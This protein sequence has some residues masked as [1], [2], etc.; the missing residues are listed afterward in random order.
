MK[1]TS[2]PSDPLPISSFICAGFEDEG[3]S[4]GGFYDGHVEKRPPGSYAIDTEQPARTAAKNTG[5]T[6]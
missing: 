6:F 2:L 4:N 3:I 1:H 5:R